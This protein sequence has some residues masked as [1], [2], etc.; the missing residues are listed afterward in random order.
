MF[1]SDRV[2][3]VCL[4]LGVDS[5]SPGI[6]TQRW[7]CDNVGLHECKRC[8][9]DDIFIWHYAYLWIYQNTG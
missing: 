3:H 1:I 7:E 8:W 2:Q 6:E 5:H 4:E 9:G